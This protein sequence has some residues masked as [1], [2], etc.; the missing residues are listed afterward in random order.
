MCA[1]V[2]SA[3]F[4][5]PLAEAPTILLT[6]AQAAQ[7]PD[8][9]LVSGLTT[10]RGAARVATVRLAQPSERCRHAQGPRSPDRSAAPASQSGLPGVRSARSRCCP[11]ARGSNKR[12]RSSGR[13]ERTWLPGSTEL[14]AGEARAGG[15]PRYGGSARLRRAAR[16]GVPGLRGQSRLRIPAR[17]SSTSPACPHASA[18]RSP[19]SSSAERTGR[20]RTSASKARWP[21]QRLACPSRE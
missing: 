12:A 13:H 1:G 17:S 9:Q 10:L 8:Q 14:R 5:V 18:A 6:G 15:Q 4:I 19:R 11:S 16:E 3:F 2:A 21:T 7:T 20:Q